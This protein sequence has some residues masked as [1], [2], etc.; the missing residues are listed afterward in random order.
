MA[1]YD[2]HVRLNVTLRW[3]HLNLR[4]PFYVLACSRRVYMAE[5]AHPNDGGIEEV[6][7]VVFLPWR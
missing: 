2:A 7:V 1:V 4:G 5:R 6:N 3:F